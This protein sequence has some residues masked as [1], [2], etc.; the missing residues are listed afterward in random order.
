MILAIKPQFY[1]FP[2]S[3]TILLFSVLILEFPPS[4]FDYFPCQ[5]YL[6]SSS[7]TIFL[8]ALLNLAFPPPP[9]FLYFPP[10]ILI[11]RLLHNFIIFPPPP[12]PSHLNYIFF[13]PQIHRPHID[14]AST[15]DSFPFFQHS[16]VDSETIYN[17]HHISIV[18]IIHKAYLLWLF[19]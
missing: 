10:S 5:L 15:L 2:S 18:S 8:F 12:P 11:S 1:Y 19:Q 13:H 16:F 17:H 4:Q 3:S 6:F 7:S 14:P 9:Q